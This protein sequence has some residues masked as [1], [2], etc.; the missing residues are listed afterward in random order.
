[1]NIQFTSPHWLW[2]LLPGVVWILWLAIKS[3]AQLSPW[4]RWL[5]TTIRLVVLVCLVV[6]LGG[7]QWKKPKEGVNV[8]FLL[9]RS[10]SVSP[11]Q[12]ERAQ[13]FV[14]EAVKEKKIED[15]G[16]VIL[17]GAGASI[18][19][20][21]SATPQL[22]QV[23][24][25]VPPERTDL[26]AAIRLGAAAL[27]EHGQKRLVILSDGNENIGNAMSAVL[28]AKPLGVTVDVL[29]LSLS[30]GG[31]VSVQKL[32][33]PSKL[34][35]GQAFDVKILVNSDGDKNAAVRLFRNDQLLG[36]QTVQLTAGKNL[37]AFPQ[38]LD[39]A[40]FYSYQVQVDVADDTIPQNNR[41]TTFANIRGDP[42]VLLVSAEMEQDQML[43]AALRSSKLVVKHVP[44]ER[45]PETLAEMQSYD[46]IFIS[47]VAAGDLTSNMLKLLE[48][49]VRDFGVGFV[50]IGGDQTYA[51][52][53]YRGT[54]LETILPV[55]MELS[56]KK[57][58]PPGALVLVIDKSGSMEGDKIEMVKTASI[59]A[60]RALGD[61]DFIGVVA[62][63]GAPFVVAELQKAGNKVPLERAISGIRAGGG[64]AMYPP[65]VKAF[66]MLRDS[67]ASLKHCIIL[68]D[69]E[70]QPGDFEGITQ[71][72]AEN[73]ITVSTVAAGDQIDGQLLQSIAQAGKGRFYH[74]RNSTQI[75]QVFIKETA[76]ILK[77]AIDEEPFRPQLANSSETVRGI[78]ASE[79]PPLLGYVATTP[80]PRAEMVLLSGKG[81]PVLAH[82]NYGLGRT[83]A[84]TSDAKSRWAKN[85]LSWG[86]YRQFWS[87]VAQWSLR[88]LENSDFNTEMAVERGEG[89]LSVEALDEQGDYRN[90]LNLE[91]TVVSPKGDRQKV[92]LEQT[93]PGHYEVRFP[94]KEIG[95]YVAQLAQTKDGNI[96]AGQVVG[97]AV[98]YSPEFESTEPNLQLLKQLAESGG[99]LTINPLLRTDNP[100]VHDRLR[101][102]QPIDLWENLLKLAIILFTLDV[103]LRRIQVGPEEWQKMAAAVRRKLFFWQARQVRPQEADE[104]LAALLNRRDQV[105][106]T[107]KPVA[108]TVD[109]ALFKPKEPVLVV[110]TSA[111]VTPAEQPMDSQPEDAAKADKPPTDE[112]TTTSRLL[113][114][115]KRARR[116]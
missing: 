28:A 95:A 84:F 74:V 82:W 60:V 61:A 90:F 19:S 83:V 12:Q 15:K 21:P 31:D 37:F 46:S 35:V 1:M 45:F 62:F 99:G 67:K 3:D 24:A 53:S 85:W 110:Q 72:M 91:A 65:M 54:P 107:Q 18:E 13:K 41:A 27:P 115:K 75:P 79:F 96:V 114:A 97:T 71:K 8:F 64:T 94:T 69:G 112:T 25:V 52:G 58:L 113:D 16:G 103:G 89:V 92:R 59:G 108:A 68:T 73:R 63:D 7:L 40:G 55:E 47:N 22:N 51:A 34:K 86:K 50:C 81:D 116:K 56:S 70:S 57:V 20:M 76:V 106:A 98:N 23:Q 5:V 102:F 78:A 49:A 4:R 38:K 39:E 77:S 30:R 111:K 80:K 26:S 14:N 43:A 44:I 104:S 29:P 6:A 36:E 9:D 17:F 48:S 100:F 101:T 10:Q 66:E 33:V 93:A 109:P 11:E 42:V 2:L 105:R 87:Q 88:K 32:T